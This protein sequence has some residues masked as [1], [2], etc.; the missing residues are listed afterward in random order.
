MR[1]SSSV[2]LFLNDSRTESESEKMIY[3]LCLFS[4]M[5]SSAISIARVSAEKMELSFGRAFLTMVSFKIAVKIMSYHN[6]YIIFSDSL[7][8]LLSLRNK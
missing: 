7:S 8:V 3:F 1:G 2:F 5:M 6:K 4:E